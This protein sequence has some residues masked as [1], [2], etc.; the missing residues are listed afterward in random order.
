MAG[1]DPRLAAGRFEPPARRALR[2]AVR[3]VLA[4]RCS[5]WHHAARLRNAHG[6]AGSFRCRPRLLWP[7]GR[8]PCVRC[9]GTIKRIVQASARPFSARHVEALEGLRV[10]CLRKSAMAGTSC[11]G[12]N[13]R[14]PYR[15]W[16]SE[17][18]LQQTQVTTVL[19]FTT[20]A[21]WNA[22][23]PC[24]SWSLPPRRSADALGRPGLLQPRPQP[25]RRARRWHLAWCAPSARLPRSCRP[26]PASA[27]PP[28]RP[29]RHCFL[30][31]GSPS[32]ITNVKRAEPSW[33][34]TATW[35]GPRRKTP[36]GPRHRPAAPA[37]T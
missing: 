23:R 1:I 35:P 10:C 34:L 14:D 3:E 26:C 11:P 21:S 33:P 16:L 37:S 27:A 5:Q 7:R 28:Q 8:A 31:S 12:S 18:M 36:V 4:G 6:V 24:W 13:T 9:G 22:S 19:G 15:V 25:A 29:S 30:A 32:R 20:R 17:I 2:Q